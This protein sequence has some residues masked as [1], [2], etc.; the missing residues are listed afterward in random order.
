MIRIILFVVV[1]IVILQLMLV[2]SS[3]PQSNKDEKCDI[4]AQ[5][6]ECVYNPNFMWSTC[7]SSCM[8][9][10][11]DDDERC[12][13]WAVEGECTNNPGYIQV[14]CPVSC[15]RQI[16]WNYWIR[17]ELNMQND[18]PF[19]EGLAAEM[20]AKKPSNLLAIVKIMYQRLEVFMSGGH[21]IV[22]GLATTAPTPFLGIAGLGEAFIY[23]LRLIEVIV[24]SYDSLYDISTTKDE[25]MIWKEHLLSVKGRV[26]SFIVDIDHNL[27][28]NEHDGLGRYMPTWV[29]YL[30]EIITE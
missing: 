19:H 13:Q 12:N 21:L 27:S 14:H 24:A 11:R 20:K 29:E 1:S 22:Q 28:Q 25:H 4:W 8:S 3:L 10:A 15:S 26:E 18:L 5:E 30:N 2:A 7:H 17:H 16:G 6:G 23:T 9:F